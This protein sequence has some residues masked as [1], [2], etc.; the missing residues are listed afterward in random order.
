[1]EEA[2]DA[3]PRPPNIAAYVQQESALIFDSTN[4]HPHL[5]HY[6]PPHYCTYS[7]TSHTTPPPL[8]CSY[9]LQVA[10][11]KTSANMRSETFPMP[12]TFRMGRVLTK[13]STRSRV[14]A[15]T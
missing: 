11:L 15:R 5:S 9:Y 3:R 12:P 14:G 8:T 2:R 4:L 6:P 10:A 7:P 13:S 1:V